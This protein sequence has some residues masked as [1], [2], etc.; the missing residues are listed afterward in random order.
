MIPELKV[1][2]TT[3]ADDMK[4]IRQAIA[5]YEQLGDLSRLPAFHEGIYHLMRVVNRLVERSER[6]L[7]LERE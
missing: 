6:P 4:H 1:F 3:I 7:S 5:Q 2:D